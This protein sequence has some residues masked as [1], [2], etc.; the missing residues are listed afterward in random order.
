M[1]PCTRW[2]KELW[3]ARGRELADQIG[4]VQDVSQEPAD[5][6]N[7]EQCHVMPTIPLLSELS[8]QKDPSGRSGLPSGVSF[9]R[10][11]ADQVADAGLTVTNVTCHM[12]TCEEDD[13][14]PNKANAII[15]TD[16]LFHERNSLCSLQLEHYW[17][18]AIRKQHEWF[19]AEGTRSWCK[20]RG[21]IGAAVLSL[22]R[23]G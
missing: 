22:D 1:A 14:P 19:T 3:L 2:Q 11:P 12:D 8:T 21:P 23:I 6:R 17:D 7:N 18:I 9:C 15:S 4:S 20:I 13:T 10:T 16:R 5:A